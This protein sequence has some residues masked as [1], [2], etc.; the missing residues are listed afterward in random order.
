MNEENPTEK[1]L[2]L[3]S[4]IQDG[5]HSIKLVAPCN[6]QTSANVLKVKVVAREVI[7]LAGTTS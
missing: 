3:G 1:N 4:N 5:L 6:R 7:I 2:A